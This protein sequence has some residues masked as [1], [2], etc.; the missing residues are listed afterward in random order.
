MSALFSRRQVMCASR[1]HGARLNLIYF[2]SP[3]SLRLGLK[4]KS[5]G[6][7]APQGSHRRTWE[8]PV[9]SEDYPSTVI[10]PSSTVPR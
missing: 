10:P 2:I 9:T 3:S 7:C 5:H 6:G 4:K 1:V 8:E